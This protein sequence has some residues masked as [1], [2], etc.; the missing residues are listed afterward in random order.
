MRECQG[1]GHSQRA[2]IQPL[3]A[4]GQNIRTVASY[5][6][7]PKPQHLH[8]LYVLK[9]QGSGECSRIDSKNGCTNSVNTVKALESYAQLGEL[10]AIWIWPLK[11][12]RGRKRTIWV[13]I[14]QS[15]F[16]KPSCWRMS[17]K[18][19]LL[20][21]WCLRGRHGD[22]SALPHPFLRLLPQSLFSCLPSVFPVVPLL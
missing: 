8:P 15:C 18:A 7:T 3:S 1:K 20:W 19:A 22:H 21:Q 14:N 16:F 5:T 13:L 6:Y 11:K 9:G 2:A 12:G 10:Y 17:L 4:Q